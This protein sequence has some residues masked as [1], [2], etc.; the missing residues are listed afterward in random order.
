MLYKYLP[1]RLFKNLFGDRRRY[2][3]QTDPDD[4]DFK[5]WLERYNDF[6]EYQS[7]TGSVVNDF[8]HKIISEVDL[9]GK[10]VLE[11]GPGLIKHL[12]NNDTRP[13]KY[14]LAD[15]NPVFLERSSAL[16]KEKFGIADTTTIMVEGIKVPLDDNSVDI[17]VT[18]HQ[19]EHIFE[20]EPYL[21]ELQRVLRPGGQVIGAVPT[22]GS[23]SWGLGRFL[24]SRRHVKKHMDFN[25]D[26]IICWEHPNF[27][28]RIKA[29]LDL[30]FENIRSVKQPFRILPMD[31]NLSWSFVYKN[32][33]K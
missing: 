2:G 29:L 32:T 12:D 27:V 8:G 19:L 6:Y 21:K 28:N 13:S 3:L 14:I 33:K 11:V 22:E 26:K 5:K 30:N 24:T 7:S 9:T 10:I 31:L 4:T 18:F 15:I 25:Y 17:I 16:L 20:L 23:I 1:Y